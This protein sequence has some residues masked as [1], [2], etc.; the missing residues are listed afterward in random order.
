MVALQLDTT[1]LFDAG[2]SGTGNFDDALGLFDGGSSNVD[3]EGTYSF[4]GATGDASIDLGSKFTS[5]VTAVLTTDRRDY[6]ETFDSED[7]NFDDKSG[8]FEYL[9]LFL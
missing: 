8:F 2:L 1:I 4:V 5:R 6:V 9:R 7:G 3:N